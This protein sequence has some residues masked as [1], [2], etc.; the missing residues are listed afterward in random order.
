MRRAGGGSA[1]GLGPGGSAKCPAASL[2]VGRAG[3]SVVR[4][5]AEMVLS[6]KGA[7]FAKKGR[8]WDFT[9]CNA[10][11]VGGVGLIKGS[12]RSPG[13]GHGNPLQY[14]CLENPIDRG[15]WW[16]TVHGITQ[17]QT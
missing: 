9:T 12:T 4:G 17:S 3:E 11:D 15:A 7:A 2:A 14:S 1:G 10:E 8:L 5:K 16:A 13:G 6:P